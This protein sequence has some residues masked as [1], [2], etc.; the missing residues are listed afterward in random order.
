MIVLNLEQRLLFQKLC[1]VLLPA[2]E[3]LPDGSTLNLQDAP[4]DTALALRPDL[5]EPLQKV[6][7][8]LAIPVDSSQVL[9]MQRNHRDEFKVIKLLACATYYQH[10]AVKSALGYHGQQALTLPRGGFGCEELVLKMMS[11]AKR[12][13]K[14][15]SNI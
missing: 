3:Q 11:G 13:R 5:C 1:G 2:W 9:Q 6:L 8:K 15:G 7:G 10:P 12:Y 4:L 14:T